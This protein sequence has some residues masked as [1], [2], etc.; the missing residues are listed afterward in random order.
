MSNDKGEDIKGMGE[1]GV[2]SVQS[3]ASNSTKGGILRGVLSWIREEGVTDGCWS[4]DGHT[5]EWCVVETV[6][7]KK[8]TNKKT[9]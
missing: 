5:V 1:A 6:K 3:N 8:K 9:R 4:W 2:D 7:E